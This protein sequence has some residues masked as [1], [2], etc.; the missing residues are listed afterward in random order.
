MELTLLIAIILLLVVLI[1]LVL[2]RNNAQPQT[3]QLQNAL[4][5][6]LQENRE[7]LNRSIR[8]L[9]MEITQTLN[10]SIQQLQD[11]LHKNMLTSGEMQRQKF[12][13]MA[14]QQ[15][16]LIQSTEKRLDD[17]RLMV[18]E[19]LQKTLNER[20]GQSFEIVRTQLEN[21]QRGLGEMKSLAQDVGGLKKVLSNVKMRGTFGEVQ[22]GAL[23]EQMMSPEQYDSNVKTKKSGTEFVE[24]AI[25]LPGKD[26]NN[27]TVYLPID[28]KFPKDIYEQYYDA[29]EAGEAA[30]IES[31]GR[32]LE[33]TIKKMAKDI[34][35]KYVDPPFTTDFAIL[36]LPFESI[37]AEVIRRTALVEMLQREYKIVVTGPTTLG[38]ILN[39]LQMGFRT[40][41]I[42]KRTGEVWS[43]LG[44]VK[45][46]F[47][48]F[49]GLLEKVQKNLQSAGDQLEEVMGKRTRAIERK[50]RQVEELP[51]EESQ[52]ILPFEESDDE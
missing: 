16:T 3:E 24:Y 10:Q 41:A 32:Q 1:I 33:N 30:L 5:Q 4:R 6:Q 7:E 38:A 25:K 27:T 35:D 20:I 8:E 15:E 9:R 42:Q 51:H 11:A 21:V 45:S 2:T 23:L 17:M 40:L 12:E 49:G 31:S 26:E 14:R 28:A 13:A 43:V 48:K 36:F 22:L 29:F 18:E 46:E 37:Y 47:G 44:A 52:K 34:H 39:S 50:L 19:K